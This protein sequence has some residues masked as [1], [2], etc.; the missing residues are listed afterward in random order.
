[1]IYCWQSR[2]TLLL[3]FSSR[4]LGYLSF[5]LLLF[6]FY[7]Y[8]TLLYTFVLY[9]CFGA[10]TFYFHLSKNTSQY[11]YQSIFKQRYLY[12]YL[13]EEKCVLLTPMQRSL[14]NVFVFCFLLNKFTSL[15][16][17][18]CNINVN[19]SIYCTLH[20]I[21]VFYCPVSQFSQPLL[22]CMSIHTIYKSIL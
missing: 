8:F 20:F 22:N 3:Y 17:T 13:S 21:H 18:V 1:M 9:V 6:C 11:F 12:F 4:L 10:C 5:T 2:N 16:F 15:L 7:F 14:S 19:C